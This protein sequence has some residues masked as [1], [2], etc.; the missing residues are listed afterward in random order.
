MGSG[1]SMQAT[2]MRRPE[3]LLAALKSLSSFRK[4]SL[5]LVLT[6]SPGSTQAVRVWTSKTVWFGSST[7]QKPDRLRLA[8][9]SRYPYLSTVG[10]GWVWLDPLFPISSSH[11]QVFLFMVTFRYPAVK[12]KI[13]TLVHC[14]L[15]LLYW[16][17]L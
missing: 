16:Q 7:V 17:P 14:Y 5:R 6:M 3:G 10:L 9:P 4:T 8:G 12:C 11:F 15:C 2:R 13:E 1:S